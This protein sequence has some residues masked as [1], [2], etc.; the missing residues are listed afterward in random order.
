MCMKSSTCCIAIRLTVH[1]ISMH[2]TVAG[3]S[4]YLVPKVS[5]LAQSTSPK[6]QYYKGSLT[7]GPEPTYYWF[8]ILE[9]PAEDILSVLYFERACKSRPR[10]VVNTAFGYTMV[11]IK[12]DER[13]IGSPYS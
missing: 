1:N 2:F 10:T 7:A 4:Y 11:C 6:A 9:H 12:N 3:R 5:Q 13:I 8:N